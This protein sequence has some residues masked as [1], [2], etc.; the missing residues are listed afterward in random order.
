MQNKPSSSSPAMPDELILHA[1]LTE[2]ASS[3][4]DL[5][6]SSLVAFEEIKVGIHLSDSVILE[7]TYLKYILNSTMLDF[8]K[9]THTHTIEYAIF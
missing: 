3:R 4:K 2:L 5:H 6:D 8:L 9:Y 7:R 1:L